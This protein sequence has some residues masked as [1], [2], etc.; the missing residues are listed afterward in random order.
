MFFDISFKPELCASDDPTRSTLE[1]VE[2][3]RESH[4]GKET[5]WLVATDGHS[6]VK[7]PV[8]GAEGDALGPISP[9]ALDAAR[10]IAKKA[11]SGVGEI[12]CGLDTL[13]LADGSILP[14]PK[15]PDGFSFPDYQRVIPPPA[16]LRH[17]DKA[18][19][20]ASKENPGPY[21]LKL[22]LDAE[23]LLQAVKAQGRKGVV[24]IL[25]TI[26]PPMVEEKDTCEVAGPLVLRAPD[27][28]LAVVMPGRVMP[29]RV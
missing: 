27:G 14:R 19:F 3:V 5:H 12:R 17:L 11:K 26:Q 15:R 16:D 6:L 18:L 24:E 9:D 21:V 13:T 28:V 25:V 8:S 20:E 10:K 29:G 7:V 1:N 2:L 4:G 22:G 23:L